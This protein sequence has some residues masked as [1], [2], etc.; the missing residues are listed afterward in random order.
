MTLHKVT[1]FQTGIAIRGVL[2]LF[3]PK[4]RVGYVVKQINMRAVFIA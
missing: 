1:F 4:E 2:M 3:F